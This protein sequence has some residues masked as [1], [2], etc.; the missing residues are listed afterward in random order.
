MEKIS[1]FAL[2]I[3][4]VLVV[5]V[6]FASAEFLKE[7]EIEVENLQQVCGPRTC[8]LQCGGGCGVPKC[9]CS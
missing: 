4:V 7:D 1:L 9:G 2:V 5:S 6:I 3:A 8:N